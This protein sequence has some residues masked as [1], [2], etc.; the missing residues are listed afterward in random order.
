MLV[1]RDNGPWSFSISHLVCCIRGFGG[2]T[3]DFF[4]EIETGKNGEDFDWS[5]RFKMNIFRLAGDMTHLMSVIVLLLKIHT[6]K[7][8]AGIVSIY[9]FDDVYVCCIAV[10]IGVFPLIADFGYLIW[11]M[12]RI[13]WIGWIEEC[14]VSLEF[15]FCFLDWVFCSFSC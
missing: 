9:Y 10:L 7:S 12:V 5:E 15:E 14:E 2:Q 6:I 11:F 1:P 4:I 13:F 3:L 8:C